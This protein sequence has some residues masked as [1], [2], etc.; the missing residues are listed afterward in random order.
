MIADYGE[1]GVANVGLGAIGANDTTPS[2]TW[3]ANGPATVRITHYEGQKIVLDV[4]AAAPALVA[5]STVAWPG[6]KLRIDGRSAP[7]SSYNHAFVGFV[8]PPGRHRAELRY[9][10]GSFVWGAALSLVSLGVGLFL[11]GW[12]RR[13]IAGP[14]LHGATGSIH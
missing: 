6:W 7:T 9:L 1:R 13:R 3:A 2:R 4:D 10:P 12:S 5:T 14:P 8:V 11:L